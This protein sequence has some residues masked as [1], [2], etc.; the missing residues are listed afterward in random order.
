MRNNFNQQP[1]S[2]TNKFLNQTAMNFVGNL[3]QKNV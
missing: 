3:P 1:P 2:R